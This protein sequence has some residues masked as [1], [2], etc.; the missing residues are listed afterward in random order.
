MWMRGYMT[1]LADRIDRSPARQRYLAREAAIQA[2]VER[3]GYRPA[4]VDRHLRG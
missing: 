4:A 3:N 1:M 2:F